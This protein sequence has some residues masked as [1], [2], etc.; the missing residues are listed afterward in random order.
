MGRKVLLNL[1]ITDEKYPATGKKYL[2]ASQY[3]DVLDWMTRYQ[4]EKQRSQNN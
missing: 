1:D 2:V 4:L 3:S